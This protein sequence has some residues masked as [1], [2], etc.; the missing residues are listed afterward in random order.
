MDLYEDALEKADLVLKMD[1]N[2]PQTLFNK[3]KT[4]SRLFKF[5]QSKSIFK[6]LKNEN[7]IENI[8]YLAL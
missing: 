4:L 3:A 7:E 8:N 1:K 5:E 2:H 6:Q